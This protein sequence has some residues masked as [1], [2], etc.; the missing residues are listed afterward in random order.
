MR[1]YTVY[2]VANVKTSMK[3][4]SLLLRRP[5]ITL[6]ISQNARLL[7]LTCLIARKSTRETKSVLQ[8]FN[9]YYQHARFDSF[10]TA[11]NYYATLYHEQS[12][13]VVIRAV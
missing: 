1:Y 12:M 10:D 8:S 7:L 13:Q 6:I 4:K 11:E 5:I 9:W 2:N 3:A